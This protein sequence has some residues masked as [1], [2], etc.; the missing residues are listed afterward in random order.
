M[1]AVSGTCSIAFVE[2]GYMLLVTDRLAGQTM[3]GS[4]EIG[5]LIGSTAI[6][7]TNLSLTG[8]IG[9]SSFALLLQAFNA[10]E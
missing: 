9:A 5:A 3:F 2:K 7:V 1:L 8:L 10:L 4:G 6:V